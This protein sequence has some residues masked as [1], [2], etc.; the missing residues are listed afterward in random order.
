MT[1]RTPPRRNEFGQ[2]VG[3]PVDWAGA[4][5][6][7]AVTLAGRHCTVVPLGP[8][9]AEDLYAAC[10]P[11]GPAAWTYLPW[12]PP[13]D[14]S[15]MAEIVD[16]VLAT[17]GFVPW[18]VL[19]PAGAAQGMCS[20]LRIE[21]RAGSIEIGAILLGASLR[22]STAATEA[23]FL[24]ARH[25]F[26]DLGYRRY[27]WK[28]DALNEPSRRAALRLGFRF[29]GVFRQ[30]LVV[31]GRN[32]DTAWFAMTDADWP[33]V[34]AALRRWLDPGNFDDAGRQRSPL[35]AQLPATTPY[36]ARAAPTRHTE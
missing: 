26:E 33:E 7:E 24:L 13:T 14:A 30:A 1:D 18:A 16:A 9:H 32:R 22:R 28:C 29:E 31:K 20:Y 35:A 34:A 19:D 11:L 10:A 27:E 12:Q 5:T 4:R 17:P 15:G 21:P 3:P 8:Q 25:A 6:P 23:M 36:A 2:P